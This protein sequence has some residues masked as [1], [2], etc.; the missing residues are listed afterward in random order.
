MK[1]IHISTFLLFI[2]SL[3][4]SGSVS[5]ASFDCNKASTPVERVICADPN[6]SNLDEQMKAIYTPLA[7]NS[8]E[9]VLSQ[10]DWL[11]YGRNTCGDLTCLTTQ[12][13]QR[14]TELRTGTHLHWAE[15]KCPQLQHFSHPVKTTS[16]STQ[17]PKKCVSSRNGSLITT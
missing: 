4:I 3:C 8:R 9:T 7:K 5:A 13:Q 16:L 12:Y 10:R 2:T 6:L 14:I 17:F 15:R 1:K 11:R